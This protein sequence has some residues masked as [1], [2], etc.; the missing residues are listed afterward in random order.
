M[1]DEDTDGPGASRPR[2]ERRTAGE[3]DRRYNRRSPASEMVPPYHATFE[4]MAVALEGIERAL[5]RRTV[6]LR[7]PSE[8]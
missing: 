6:D 3:S 1:V 7:T 2:S 5:E 4:R 8:Q